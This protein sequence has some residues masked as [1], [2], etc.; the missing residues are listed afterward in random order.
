MTTVRGD[1][2]PVC[3]YNRKTGEESYGVGEPKAEGVQQ[4]KSW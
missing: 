2:M 1:Y 3:L 4:T